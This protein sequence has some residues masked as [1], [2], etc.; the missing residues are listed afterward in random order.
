MRVTY[1]KKVQLYDEAAHFWAEYDWD[2]SEKIWKCGDGRS[3]EGF[4]YKHPDIPKTMSDHQMT[5]LAIK[6]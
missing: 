1:T 5:L 6:G 2:S 4:F 3:S